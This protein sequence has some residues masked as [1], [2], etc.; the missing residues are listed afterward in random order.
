MC[1]IFR[2][3]NLNGAPIDVEAV[4][5]GT[6][7]L[8]HRRPDNEGYLLVNTH[9]GKTIL[10]SGLATHPGSGLPLIQTCGKF[11]N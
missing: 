9:T 8:R 3:H 6:T 7:L 1:D 5:R 2:I 10:C 4:E 11:I